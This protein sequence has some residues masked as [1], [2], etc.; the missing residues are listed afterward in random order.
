MNR[1]PQ[2]NGEHTAH[3]VTSASFLLAYLGSYPKTV[4][5][6][7]ILFP[8]IAHNQSRQSLYLDLLPMFLL[9]ELFLGRQ[10][11]L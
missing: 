11:Y 10:I 3:Y 4:G 5:G 6:R 1:S 9:V 2:N 8:S 7:W